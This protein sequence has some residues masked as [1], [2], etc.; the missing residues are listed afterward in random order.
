[1][2]ADAVA[3][4]QDDG[5]NTQVRLIFSAQPKGVVVRTEPAAGTK[6]DKGS[7][8]TVFVS[9]GPAVRERPELTRPHRSRGGE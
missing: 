1:V 5:F 8:V 9:R 6:V 3:R 4:L 7:T 2:R